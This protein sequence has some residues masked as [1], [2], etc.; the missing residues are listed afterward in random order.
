VDVAALKRRIGRVGVWNSSLSQE[1]ASFARDAAAE[2]ERLGF[3]ALWVGEGPTSKEA[4]VHA[5]ILLNATQRLVV[6]TGIANIW[7]RDAA[8]ASNGA[9]ALA[10][11][12]G[13]RFLLGLGV[14]HSPAVSVRG[15]DYR[16]PLAVM[17]A[18]LQAMD[19]TRYAGPLPEPA[20]RVLAALRP[21]ML[22]L[23][24]QRTQ[25]AHPYFVTTEHT[26]SARAI[27]GPGPLLAPEQAV[28]LDSDPARARDTARRHMS[29]YLQL[30]N[31]VNNLRALGWADRDLADGGSDALVDAIVSWGDPQAI[32][33]RVRAHHEA[34]ADHVSLQPLTDTPGEML[35]HL[36]VLAPALPMS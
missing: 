2:V 7:A 8:A 16:Q 31:Y 14:S 25:G 27:L 1:S 33:G 28:V 3:G 19:A 6:A 10:E 21:K 17:R 5:A 11:A 23:A 22:E 13:G 24:G 9:N 12:S 15:H 4:L 20:P 26:A 18:Y 36:R 32:A 29:G 35:E 30:P 34:G